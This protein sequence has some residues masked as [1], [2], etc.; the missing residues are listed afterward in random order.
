MAVTC[1]ECQ[2]SG[3]IAADCPNRD[4]LNGGQPWCGICDQ[5]THLVGT[6]DGL[7]RCPDCHPKRRE[8]LHQH[9]RCPSCRMVVHSWDNSP[10]G[11]HQGPHATDRRLPREQ[12]EEI[13]T[14]D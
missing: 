7:K 1:F 8:Q 2:Q 5:R 9:R 4:M 6:P 14:G 12:I 11:Q 3:H 13:I 10:C